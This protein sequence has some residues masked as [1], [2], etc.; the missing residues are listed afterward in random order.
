MIL[1]LLRSSQNFLSVLSRHRPVITSSG[2]FFCTRVEGKSN[3]DEAA[4]LPYIGSNAGSWR[5][6]QTRSGPMM[7]G[8]WYQPYVVMGCLIIFMIY[9]CIIRE[10]NDI[11]LELQKTLY[12]RIDGLEEAQLRIRHKYNI[13]NGLDV[14]DIEARLK[15]LGSNV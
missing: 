10:E 12:E 13:E 9:F 6:Q 2:R 15:E 7:H 3:K 4:P 11:D 5:A 1:R 8:V 14:K